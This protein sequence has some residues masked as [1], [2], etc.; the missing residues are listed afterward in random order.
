MSMPFPANAQPQPQPQPQIQPQP[1]P[2]VI[3]VTQAPAADGSTFVVLQFQTALGV[4]VF[5]LDAEAACRVG[6]QIRQA[7][8]TA[9]VGLTLP[10]GVSLNGDDDSDP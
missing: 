1:L 5:F 3:G 7:G 6:G 9:R 8:R 4:H 10:H 2:T